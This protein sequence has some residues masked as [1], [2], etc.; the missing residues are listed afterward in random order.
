MPDALQRMVYQGDELLQFPLKLPNLPFLDIEGNH[1]SVEFEHNQVMPDL[2]VEILR[3]APSLLFVGISQ[4]DRKALRSTFREVDP[5]F[6]RV[7]FGRCFLSITCLQ[8][9][10]VERC[11]SQE[12]SPPVQ[13]SSIGESQKGKAALD[14]KVYSH[15]SALHRNSTTGQILTLALTFFTIPTKIGRAVLPGR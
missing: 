7:G 2:V 14:V 8:K 11:P 6:H 1:L 12:S 15:G 13:F 4:F 10:S 3:E 5:L 9:E